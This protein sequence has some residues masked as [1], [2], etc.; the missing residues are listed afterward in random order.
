[1]AASMKT[2]SYN[3]KHRIRASLDASNFPP[4][5]HPLHLY[6]TRNTARS[7][8][9]ASDVKQFYLSLW[10]NTKLST[11]SPVKPHPPGQSS[12]FQRMLSNSMNFPEILN[13][14]QDE[15]NDVD[16]IDSFIQGIDV[17][18]VTVVKVSEGES[19]QEFSEDI[20]LRCSTL[21]MTHYNISSILVFVRPVNIFDVSNVVIGVSSHETYQWLTKKDFCRRLLSAVK[22][23]SVLVRAKDVFLA[24]YETFLD[25]PDFKRPFYF[26]MYILECSPLQQGL[27]TTSTE[28][29]ITYL[30]DLEKEREEFRTKMESLTSLS[31]R[32]PNKITGPWK[33]HFIS[34]F[35]SVLNPNYLSPDPDDGVREPSFRTKAQAIKSRRKTQEVVGE[36]DY[37]I[38]PQ[39]WVFKRMMWLDSKMPNFDPLYFVGM[40]RKLMIKNSLF[41]GSYV[42]LSPEISEVD[43]DEELME[44][45]RI[46]KERLCMVRCLGKEYDRSQKLFVT[47]LCIFNMVKKPPIVLPLHLVLKV[48]I[49]FMLKL[50]NLVNIKKSCQKQI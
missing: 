18:I 45:K 30:G 48:S 21:F 37:E 33:D 9:I 38:I 43:Y 8:G 26:D 14:A 13:P 5:D 15:G 35:S 6:V 11:E 12:I 42:L 50:T 17:E 20:L 22:N 23:N 36:F 31:G 39:H 3:T 29:V 47:P 32:A 16:S 44:D 10:S 41:D 4:N 46:P 24:P 7:L 34:D 2:E 49:H 40:S 25:D 27:I 28:L 1:M 19:P